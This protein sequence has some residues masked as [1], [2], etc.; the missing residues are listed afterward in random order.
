MRTY[1]TIS[2][3]VVFN[4]IATLAQSE[5]LPKRKPGLWAM[6]IEESGKAGPKQS[7]KQCVD[8]KTDTLLQVNSDFQ[9]ACTQQPSR[10]T[11]SGYETETSCRIGQLV[12][13]AKSVLSGDFQTRVVSEV[14]VTVTVAPGAPPRTSRQ[15]I[16]AAYIGPCGTDQRPGGIIM[17]DG[18]MIQVPMMQ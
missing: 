10:R 14:V 12:S 3:A 17:P 1:V 13:E 16:E 9:S 18:K 4:C 6:T 5:S 7:I 15:R 2:T 8:E 11:S